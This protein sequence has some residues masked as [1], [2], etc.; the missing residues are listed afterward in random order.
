MKPILH[1][2]L[3]VVISSCPLFAQSDI[4]ELR[5]QITD[6]AGIGVQRTVELVSEANQFRQ[7]NVSDPQ[8]SLT[9]RRIPFGV[10]RLEIKGPEFAA[11]SEFIEIRVSTPI[12]HEIQLKLH[13]VCNCERWQYSNRP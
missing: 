12:Y 2:L 4:G 6:P 7:T 8:G 1:F 10:Y 3:I 13:R 9:V 5:L 11:V